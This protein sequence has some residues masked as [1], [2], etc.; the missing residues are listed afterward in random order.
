MDCVKHTHSSQAGHPDHKQTGAWEG[1]TREVSK[2][3]MLADDFYFS[4]SRSYKLSN[5]LQIY[6][7]RCRLDFCSQ[8]I[9]RSR[10]WGNEDR[11]VTPP[12]RQKVTWVGAEM[13]SGREFPSV[14]LKMCFGS[15]WPEG[16]LMMWQLFGWHFVKSCWLLCLSAQ[17]CQGKKKGGGTFNEIEK[18]V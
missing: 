5:E 6:G 4:G 2:R 18:E 1:R 16:L 14:A 9:S 3:K 7:A 8:L 15:V 12:G 11:C 17:C 13:S 10:H